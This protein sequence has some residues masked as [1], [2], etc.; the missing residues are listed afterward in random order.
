MAEAM[1]TRTRL[2]ILLIST[3]LLAFVVFLV[4]AALPLIGVSFLLGGVEPGE[5]VRGVAMVLAV[6]LMKPLM[7]LTPFVVPLTALPIRV[8]AG[9]KLVG[10]PSQP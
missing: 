5:V 3:P 10:Q 4:F 8:T 1:T 2:S 7:L 6:L 9:L